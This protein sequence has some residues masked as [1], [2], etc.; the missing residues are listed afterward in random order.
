MESIRAITLD[1]DDTLWAIEPVIEKAEQALW[2]FLA[3]NYPRIAKNFSA[4]DVHEIRVAVMD[5][6]SNYWHDFRFLRKKVLER[7][8]TTSGYSPDLV[9]PAFAVFDRARNDVELFP[10]VL[11]ELETLSHHFT[12]VALTNGN[13]NLDTIGIG[14]FFADV[15]ASA[16]VGVSKPAKQIFDVAVASAGFHPSEILHVGDHPETDIDGARAAGLRTAWMN[17]VDAEWP[18]HLPAPDSIVTTIGELARLLEP[19]R[20]ATQG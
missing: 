6:Y 18:Q 10:D 8:A 13:A 9:E 17:R 7:I 20:R 15:I 12:L 11:P 16:D 3:D 14:H 5:E 1:L 19:A 2:Q 4:N